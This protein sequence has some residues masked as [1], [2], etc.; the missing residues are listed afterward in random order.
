MLKSGKFFDFSYDKEGVYMRIREED[1]TGFDFIA[2]VDL[3][4]G[5]LTYLLDTSKVIVFSDIQ[6]TFKED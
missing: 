4:D 2:V 6:I 3:F 5:E 1:T